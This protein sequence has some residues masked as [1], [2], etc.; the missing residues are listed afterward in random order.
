MDQDGYTMETL[1]VY[2]IENGIE[3]IAIQNV[4]NILHLFHLPIVDFLVQAFVRFV[5]L[6]KLC[7]SHEKQV[8]CRSAG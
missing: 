6:T 5:F 4:C 7:R 8:L 1:H 2:T 3:R